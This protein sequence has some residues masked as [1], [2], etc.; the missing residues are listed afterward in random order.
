MTDVQTYIKS[1][2]INPK[3]NNIGTCLVRE[4]YTF[5][6]KRRKYRSIFSQHIF[7]LLTNNQSINPFYTKKRLS[8]KNNYFFEIFTIAKLFIKQKA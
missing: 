6:V 1:I 3:Y 8:V 2:K 4:I 5:L 7:S